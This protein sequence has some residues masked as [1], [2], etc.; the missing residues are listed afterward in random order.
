MFIAIKDAILRQIKDEMG[1]NDYYK[2]DKRIQ[3]LS[4]IDIFRWKED[5]SVWG[6]KREKIAQHYSVYFDN[7]FI[8]GFDDTDSKEKVMLEWWKGLKQAITEKKLDID[9]FKSDQIRVEKENLEKEIEKAK[10]ESL[11]KLPEAN[12]THKLAKE[13]V[14]RVSKSATRSNSRRK[15]ITV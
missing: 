8:C 5:I 14:K 6:Q 10:Q 1:D 12:E 15:A 2:F 7:I 3:I 11:N 13:A 4:D 9:P